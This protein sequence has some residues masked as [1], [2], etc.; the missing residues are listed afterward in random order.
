MN[1]RDVSSLA[2]TLLKLIQ[3]AL[4][5]QEQMLIKNWFKTEIDFRLGIP[6][7]EITHAATERIVQ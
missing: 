4:Q 1:L 2:D 3:P 5:K 6:A 7:I